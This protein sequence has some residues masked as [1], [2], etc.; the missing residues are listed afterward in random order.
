M[1]K[2]LETTKCDYPCH[3]YLLDK[4]KRKCHGYIKQGTKTPVMFSRP[5]NF[6]PRRRTFKEI[7]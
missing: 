4:D 7:K 3:V 6:D 2:F 1:I 5:I